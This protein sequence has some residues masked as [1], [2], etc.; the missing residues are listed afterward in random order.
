MAHLES[1]EQKEK[2]LIRIFCIRKVIFNGSLEQKRLYENIDTIET[3]I[4]H[5]KLTEN[6]LNTLGSSH[7]EMN[8]RSNNL[9]LL[10]KFQEQ[11]W[12]AHQKFNES[13][14]D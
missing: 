11:L 1:I 10:M 7:A 13:C 12:V 6:L 14:G 9:Q 3:T 8:A 2:E 4:K 5:L